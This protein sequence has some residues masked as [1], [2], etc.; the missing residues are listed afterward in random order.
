[1]RPDWVATVSTWRF[2]SSLD[3]FEPVTPM[4]SSS[5]ANASPLP[6]DER[7][8]T[9]NPSRASLRAAAAPM[10]LPPAVTRATFRERGP[11]HPPWGDQDQLLPAPRQW[12]CS[13][14]VP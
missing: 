8:A 13:G 12:P 5:L 6:D 7:M 14:A 9:R 10:P 3:W 1:M 4:P 11:M 2:R